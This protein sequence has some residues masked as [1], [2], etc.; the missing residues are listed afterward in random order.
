MQPSMQSHVVT[1]L[2]FKSTFYLFF[3]LFVIYFV[4][5]YTRKSTNVPV[6]KNDSSHS[7]IVFIGNLYTVHKLKRR[8]IFT[9]NFLLIKSISFETIQTFTTSAISVLPSIVRLPQPLPRGCYCRRQM[10]LIVLHFVTQMMRWL[11]GKR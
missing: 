11:L 2:N 10:A 8:N 4:K 3:Y 6:L 9:P 7:K 5:M 1:F